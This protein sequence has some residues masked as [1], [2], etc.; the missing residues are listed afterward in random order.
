[1][2]KREKID[3]ITSKE[4][5]EALRLY[6][7]G[8][9]Y[10]KA[11]A[12]PKGKNSW[13]NDSIAKQLMI[14]GEEYEQIDHIPDRRTDHLIVTNLGRVLNTRSIRQLTPFTT[15][16]HFIYNM[17]GTSITL[18]SL[19]EHTQFDYD[20]NTIKNNYKTNKWKTKVQNNTS[21]TKWKGTRSDVPKI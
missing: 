18:K 20:F 4:Y 13:F 1:M 8:L 21:Y 5:D 6:Y 14:E 2:S 17:A 9:D 3:Y 12:E 10:T 16:F 15:K 7:N 19:F 11:I